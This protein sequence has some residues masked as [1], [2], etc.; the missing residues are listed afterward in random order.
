MRHLNDRRQLN[1]N[2]THRRAMF[3][4]MT[5]SL[6]LLGRIETTEA[7]AKELRREVEKLITLGKRYHSFGE[8]GEDKDVAA[9][10]LHVHRQALAYL[11]DKKAIEAILKDLPVRFEKRSGG[12]TRIM[13]T[14]VRRGDAAQMALIEILPQDKEA[15]ETKTKRRRRRTKAKTKEEGAVTKSAAAEKS[16]EK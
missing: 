2:S 15:Q 1:R 6:L 7:K 12:Y 9:K 11:K 14:N 3:R 16:E 4:N 10:K 8:V 5:T 13:K